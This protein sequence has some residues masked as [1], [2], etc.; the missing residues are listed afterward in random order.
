MKGD[1]SCLS[2]VSGSCQAG[3]GGGGIRG[4]LFGNL[5]SKVGSQINFVENFV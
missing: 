2:L 1:E 5:A 4:K 3:Q